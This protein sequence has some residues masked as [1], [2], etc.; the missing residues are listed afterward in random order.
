MS[1]DADA[2]GVGKVLSK[3]TRTGAEGAARLPAA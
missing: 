3:G 2:V 1:T